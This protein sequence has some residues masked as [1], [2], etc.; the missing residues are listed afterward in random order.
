M[1]SFYGM[2]VFSGDT[3]GFFFLR[4]ILLPYSIFIV[5]VYLFVSIGNN[6][7]GEI[8]ERNVRPNFKRFYFHCSQKKPFVYT[9]SNTATSIHHDG[10]CGVIQQKRAPNPYTNTNIMK[11][12]EIEQKQKSE[13]RIHWVSVLGI[14]LFDFLFFKL[15]ILCCFVSSSW[16]ISVALVMGLLNPY[17][18]LWSPISSLWL[19]FFFSLNLFI[20]KFD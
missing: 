13:H 2:N 1:H 5:R 6:A 18:P 8:Q 7:E 10:K 12:M 15:Q 11:W 16:S 4:P 9:F 17:A 3:V 14:H 20:R 19:S